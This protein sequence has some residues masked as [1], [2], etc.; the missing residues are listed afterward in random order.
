VV[1]PD[2]NEG[3]PTPDED[4][5][6]AVATFLSS[7]AAPAGV[8]VVAAATRFH[9]IKIEAAITVIEGFDAGK[10]VRD[11]LKAL[12]DFLHPLKG[13]QDGS[14]WPFGGTVG[15][16]ALVRRLTNVSGVAAVPTLNI[17]ADGS[18]FLACQDFIPEANALL[19]PEL[20]QIVIQDRKEVA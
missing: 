20:H 17:I 5:L 7:S 15:Y 16:Q 12:N 3:P 19:W 11:S 6:R 9:R 2:R 14:G 4:T 10:V 13:G 18:R 1:P 8:E